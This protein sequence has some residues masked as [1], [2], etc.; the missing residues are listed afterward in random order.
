MVSSPPSSDPSPPERDPASDT[1]AS[2]STVTVLLALAANLAVGVLKL[3]AGLLT[4][5]GALL[6]EAAHSVGD[7]STELLLLTALRRSSRPADRRHPFGYG[8]ER[9]FWSLL[10]AVGIL[11]SGAA[12]S[13]FEGLR[14][15]LGPNE[16]LTYAWVN[17]VVLAL[18]FV[19]EATSFRQAARQTRGE[20]ADRQRSVGAY[21][22]DPDDPTV[23][24]V[25]LE[26][27]AA[28]IGIVF[29]TVGVGL[30]QM[31]GSSV[32][33]GAAS[34]AIGM[35]LVVAAALLAQTCKTLLIGKQADVALIRRISDWLED[36]AEIDDVVDL[37]TMMLGTDRILFC[38]RVDFVDTFTAADLEQAC[39]RI[40]RDLRNK[41]PTLEEIFIEPVPRSDPQLRQRV[42]DRYG[43]VLADESTPGQ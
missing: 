5:S 15:I 2:G 32:W 12:F 13:V 14:T 29:A 34:L 21:I 7:T 1:G 23:R 41:F 20:A 16:E 33:D 42:L 26:D 10:A 25:V 9:Y 24:S 27:S 28:L 4:G 8:K 30:H 18:A 38:A 19:L 43:R 37:M 11:I 22:R 6:S 17:Y 3:V 35:L 39:A 36:Q 31:T 40:D